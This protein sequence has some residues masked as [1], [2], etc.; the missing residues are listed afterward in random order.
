MRYLL[1]LGLAL[2]LC[3]CRE[4]YRLNSNPS[5]ATVYFDDQPIG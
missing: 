1:A 2:I 5:G 3:A 4:P